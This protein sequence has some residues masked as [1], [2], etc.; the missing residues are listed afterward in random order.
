MAFQLLSA[1]FFSVQLAAALP[2]TPF[3][4]KHSTHHTR[5]FPN[6]A[7][8]TT[9]HPETNF[10]VYERGLSLRDVGTHRPSNFRAASVRFIR[11]KHGHTNDNGDDIEVISS[12]KNNHTSHVWVRQLVNGI[13]VVNTMANVAMNSKGEVVSYGSSLVPVKT[14]KSS[15]IGAGFI[16]TSKLTPDEAVHAAYNL[17]GGKVDSKRPPTLAYLADEKGA[18]QLTHTVRMHYEDMHVMDIFVDAQDGSVRGTVDYTSDLTVR[19]VPVQ[20]KDVGVSGQSI[21]TN[22]EDSAV[23]PKGWTY[24]AGGDMP[25]DVTLGNNVIA[26]FIGSRKTVPDLVDAIIKNVVPMSSPGTFD[27]PVDLTLDPNDPTNRKAAIVNIF[28]VVNSAHDILYRYGFTEY[29]FNFQIDNEHPGGKARDP[30]LISV[31]D[32]S[33]LDNASMTTLPDGQAS[34][35]DML[36]WDFTVPYRDSSFDNSVIFHEYAHGLTNRMTGGGTAACLQTTE[37]RGLGEGW[38]D[39][40]ADWVWQVGSGFDEVKDYTIGTYLMNNLSGVRKY[41]YSTDRA[42]NPLTYSS[43]R[44]LTAPHEIGQVW[45]QTLHVVHASLVHYFG[46]GSNA[47]TNPDGLTGSS[48][49]MRLIVDALALQPC[50]PTFASA[51]LAILQA[52]RIRYDGQHQCTLWRAFAW[53]GLGYGAYTFLESAGVPRDCTTALDDP[54]PASYGP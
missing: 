3:H 30:V 45:A 4:T 23:S 49:F 28:F 50:Q 34:Y 22:V 29:S 43:A 15:K 27:Y 46:S 9:Y 52:D 44:D 7:K 40:F 20:S 26:A 25:P 33:E 37:A 13:P 5:S 31:Q 16:K 41:P 18:L 10:E 32:T 21:L 36:L 14:V 42:T 53:T 39:A 48:I 51:R 8:I 38:S 12:Y 1:F 2:L 54:F 6:G 24:T 35:M 47:L 19:A 11:T 17:L